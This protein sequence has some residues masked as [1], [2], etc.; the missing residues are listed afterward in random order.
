MENP[1]DGPDGEEPTQ[2]YEVRG[3]GV[4]LTNTRPDIDSRDVL[5]RWPGHWT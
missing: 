3:F 4:R 2:E 1:M 5:H